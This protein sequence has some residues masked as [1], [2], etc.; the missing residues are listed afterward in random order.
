M[1]LVLPPGTSSTRSNNK[2]N[3]SRQHAKLL[4]FAM[5]RIKAQVSNTISYHPLHSPSF[6]TA[7][8]R[9]IYLTLSCSSQSHLFSSPP[10][11]FSPTFKQLPLLNSPVAPPK[12]DGV[13]GL[14]YACYDMVT[15]EYYSNSHHLQ[16][17]P[18]C[19]R[20]PELRFSKGCRSGTLN[21]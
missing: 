17:R 2:T 14:A 3:R 18:R 12:A 13:G 5:E 11:L 20:R 15:N 21:L 16:R 8:L 6:L 9:S 10:W 7:H 1:P 19:L 4:D